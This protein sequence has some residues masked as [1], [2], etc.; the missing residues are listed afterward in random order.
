M[1]GKNELRG[2]N[3]ALIKTIMMKKLILTAS[4]ILMISCLGFA[5]ERKL[6]FSIGPEL[7]FPSGS[8]AETHSIGT[9]GTAQ[10]EVLLQDKLKGIA[11]VGVLGYLGKSVTINN[12]KYKYPG[13]TMIPVKIGAKY[14][15]SGGIYGAAE[16]GVAFRGNYEAYSG[17]SFAYTPL[18]LGYEFR[19]KSDKAI[20]ASVKYDAT[21]GHG[22]TLGAIGIR[23]AYIF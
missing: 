7:S 13:I 16:I 14:Y 6:T 11:T 1:F 4:M 20:D 22:G 10:V 2:L 8:F 15:L 9:G 17:T 18:M 3:C 5:Q 19:T 23:L 21:S 12:V